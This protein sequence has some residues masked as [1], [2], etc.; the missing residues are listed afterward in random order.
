MTNNFDSAQAKARKASYS[1]IFLLTPP[2]EAK[3]IM[4]RCV[5]YVLIFFYRVSVV[6]LLVAKTWRPD[7]FAMYPIFACSS[8]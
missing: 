5:H 1:G 7:R 4:G 8:K 2:Q 6:V 3:K